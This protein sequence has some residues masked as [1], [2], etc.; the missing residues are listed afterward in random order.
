MRN[1][2]AQ[3]RNTSHSNTMKAV[4]LLFFASVELTYGY[5]LGA[6]AYLHIPFCRRRCYY[7]DFSIEVIGD[8]IST[9]EREAQAYTSLIVEE[10]QRTT[11]SHQHPQKL[12]TVYFGGGTPSLLP[13]NHVYTILHA[14]DKEIGIATDAE[15]TFEMDPATFDGDK[16]KGLRE[17]GVNRISLGIQSFNDDILAKS[18]RAHRV[19]DV[20]R[21]LDDVTSSKSIHILSFNIV[22]FSYKS[23]HLNSFI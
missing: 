7:C 10:I 6:G 8:R 19:E 4:L 16:I 20:Y 18:G 23:C 11:F 2:K 15:I 3:L 17:I 13:N 14:L 22:I 9:Q 21:A 12:D 5:G 1:C